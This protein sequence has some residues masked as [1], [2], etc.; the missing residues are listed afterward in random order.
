MLSLHHSSR[1]ATHPEFLRNNR[2]LPGRESIATIKGT[3][4]MMCFATPDL[5]IFFLG[6]SGFLKRKICIRRVFF[7]PQFLKLGCYGW[8]LLIL[9]LFLTGLKY[10]S[11]CKWAET[12]RNLL[13][14][15]GGRRSLKDDSE[16]CSV[17]RK[18]GDV[19]WRTLNLAPLRRLLSS[20]MPKPSMLKATSVLFL[21]L[22][23]IKMQGK[24][25]L[26]HVRSL[27]Q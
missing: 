1:V 26:C 21:M 10:T 18:K 13:S 15:L 22:G 20:K 25:H 17:R 12:I 8:K 24:V 14:F 6:D 9:F 19:N 7:I 3:A 16:K 2:N 23:M 11:T 5:G 4:H 27:Q